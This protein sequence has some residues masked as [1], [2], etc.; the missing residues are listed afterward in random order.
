MQLSREYTAASSPLHDL[1]NRA[2]FIQ[3]VSSE[4]NEVSSRTHKATIAPEH[5][6]KA[7]EEL[8]LPELLPGVQ[9]AWDQFKEEARGRSQRGFVL[10]CRLG[11]DNARARGRDGGGDTSMAHAQH[12]CLLPASAF[13]SCS[14]LFRS[15][16]EPYRAQ[17]S[18]V[19]CPPHHAARACSQG[20]GA[21]CAAAPPSAACHAVSHTQKANLR[22][23]GAESAGLTQ[24]E[25]VG[26]AAAGDLTWFHRSKRCAMVTMY[27]A[28]VLLPAK[29]PRRTNTWTLSSCTLA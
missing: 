2:E 25:Q 10:P 20:V 6:V 26:H 3:L 14:T 21:E 12:G 8:G 9:E 5:V 23:T 11:I 7:L 29:I 22:K 13:G 18:C 4:S 16:M 28:S 17:R 15:W 1:A 24:E 27:P 19:A